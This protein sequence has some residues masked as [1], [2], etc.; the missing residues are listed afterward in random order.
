M[1]FISVASISL[2]ASVSL[3][4]FSVVLVT[5]VSISVV[6]I[7]VVSISVFALCIA[8]IQKYC[9]GG[10]SESVSYQPEVPMISPPY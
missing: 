9:C 8:I 10:G 6:L 5:V 3:L 1:G 2:L 4:A 7:S